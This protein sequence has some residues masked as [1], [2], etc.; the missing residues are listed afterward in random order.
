VYCNQNEI[1][2]SSDEGVGKLF[3]ESKNKPTTNTGKVTEL[4]KNKYQLILQPKTNY[5]I[6]YKAL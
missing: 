6:K 5:Q 1:N 2:V 3:F 4:G